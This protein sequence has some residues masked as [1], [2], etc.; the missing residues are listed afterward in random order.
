MHTLI[1]FLLPAMKKKQKKTKKN[2]WKSLCVADETLSKAMT[3]DL[4]SV[5]ND[6][7]MRLYKGSLQ[8]FLKC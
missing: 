8:G 7:H 1:Y 4:S 3:D 5:V 6:E 2:G